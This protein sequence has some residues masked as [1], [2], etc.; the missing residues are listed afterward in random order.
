MGPAPCSSS[1]PSRPP[2]PTISL[3]YPAVL[4]ATTATTTTTLKKTACTG[5]NTSK[6]EVGASLLSG[7]TSHPLSPANLLPTTNLPV[8]TIKTTGGELLTSSEVLLGFFPSYPSK[9]GDKGVIRARDAGYLRVLDGSAL[10]LP[11]RFWSLISPGD[12]PPG[13]RKH[14][15]PLGSHILTRDR[16]RFIVV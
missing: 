3:A 2:S 4:A 13:N 5:A 11:G 10:S 8:P 9:R 7:P 12:W 14:S 16:L 6:G 15:R 1:R